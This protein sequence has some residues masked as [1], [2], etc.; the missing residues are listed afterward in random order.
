M[1]CIRI[2][3]G[4]TAWFCFILIAFILS[5]N[6][7]PRTESWV[8]LAGWPPG[9]ISAFTAYFY[10]TGLALMVLFGKHSSPLTGI[11]IVVLGIFPWYYGFQ[12]YE[13]RKSW[14]GDSVEFM[15][16]TKWSILIT[17]AGALLLILTGALQVLLRN[18]VVL[19]QNALLKKLHLHNSVTDS[20]PLDLLISGKDR[21]EPSAKEAVYKSPIYLSYTAISAQV[22]YL[23]GSL[24]LMILCSVLSLQLEFTGMVM[25]FLIFSMMGIVLI[26]LFTFVICSF[27]LHF[28]PKSYFIV[29]LTVLIT[30]MIFGIGYWFYLLSIGKEWPFW[31]IF[32]FTILAA[33]WGGLANFVF[34][35]LLAVKS[36]STL[37]NR[38]KSFNLDV[39]DRIL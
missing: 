32:F 1:K 21:N 14:V 35:R 20:D 38:G 12:A 8:T 27:L 22:G 15:P 7:G 6:A 3:A 34:L 23:L 39:H 31:V 16:A 2:M 24:L 10:V 26:N 5:Q 36:T 9:F 17:W 19:L 18:K 37:I 4:M 11:L 33:I 30:G 29:F 28:K 13:L 25:A